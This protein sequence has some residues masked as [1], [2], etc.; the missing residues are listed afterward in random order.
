LRGYDK[1]RFSFNTAG[2]RCEECQG[3]GYQ[4]VGMHF[5]GNVEILCEKCEGKRFD[6]ETLEVTYKGK[7]IFDVLDMYVSEALE[8]FMDQPGILRFLHTMNDLGLGYLKL[9]QRSTTLSGGEAQRVKLA[10]E[11]AFTHSAHTLYILDEPTTGLHQADVRVLLSALDTLIQQENTVILIEHHL[12]VIAASYHVIDLGPGSEKEGGSVV[13]TGT[14]EGIADCTDSYTGQALREYMA[15]INYKPEAHGSRFTVH[16][17]QTS[18]S[19]IPH[20]ITHTSSIK[21]PASSISFDGV[22]TNN[23][24][25][26]SVQIPHNKITVMT[27][28][29]G[30]GKSSL[31]FDTVFAE[32]RNCFLESFSTYARTRLG[33]KDKPDF[34]EVSGLT[35]TLAVDQRMIGANP[36]STVG[37]MTGIYDFYRLLYAR[38][39]R[40]GSKAV[41]VLSSLFSFNHRHGACPECDGLG[42]V[43]VCDPVLLVTHPERSIL[44]GALDGTKTG[45]FY[46]DPY[47]QYVSTLKAVGK[48]RSVDFSLPWHELPD[49]A[50]NLA[51]AGAGD[52]IF[53][54]TWEYRRNKREG[55]HHFKGCWQGFVFL[56]NEEYIRKHADHRGNEMMDVMKKE[57][58]P[59]CHGARLCSEALSY[60]VQGIN[61]AQLS[62]ITVSASIRFFRDPLFLLEH[63]ALKIIASPLVQDILK[64]LEFIHGMGLSYLS[65][66][67]SSSTLSGG[68]AQRI[69][70]AGQIASELTGITYVLDEPTIGLHPADVNRLMEMIRNLQRQDNTVVIVEHDRD[71]ILSADHIIDLGPGAGSLGGKILAEGSPEEIIHNAASV[72]GPFLMKREFPLNQPERQLLP[73][74]FIRNANA[75]NLK[76]F[77]LTIPCGGMTV[78]TGV[79]GSGKSSL[80]FDVLFASWKNSKPNG[81]DLING[82]EQFELVIPVHP[83]S[84][85]TG[86]NGTAA[87]FTGIFDKIRELFAKS[88]DAIRLNLGK[89][90]F[91]FLN[92]EGGCPHCQGAGKIRVSMDFMS[93]VPVICEECRGMRYNS[94]VLSCRYKEKT[95]A[96]VLDMSFS[97]ASVF[98]NDQKIVPG[99]KILEN[100]GLGYLHLGQSLDTLSG[101]ESQR[102]MLA[103][104]L[105]KPMKGNNLY[106]FEEPSTGLHFLDI[107]HLN[108]LFQSLTD[109]GHTLLIIEHDPEIILHA[110][111]IIDL[112]PGGGD[113]GGSVV[114]SGRLADIL[115]NP[116]SAT[117]IFLYKY[118]QNSSF[119]N[120]AD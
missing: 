15:S 110:D 77:N 111:W 40:S 97:E 115:E 42:S 10:T 68:E 58:C 59:S 44:A 26:I 4:E 27:G 90:H 55:Q 102:L 114:A 109:K 28:I 75:N 60:K 73:G 96:E 101:G 103:K 53:D 72:T 3:A 36:R 30:S 69:R 19:L 86:S 120:W 24:Q 16:E 25:N 18:S 22:S 84:E 35:P 57:Q 47:G 76:G 70:L 13:V 80:L 112:G 100:V 117:G 31:A 113:M 52:E 63:P 89:N 64:R 66:D 37:T 9:G 45:K 5:M 91:S 21:H 23:L 78:I 108:E 43:T 118:I 116:D 17:S 49:H 81:C 99:L 33:M 29:S 65:V 39:G 119:R 106:L 74:L 94:T 85:F 32:G 14:P 50:K 46:G 95:I 51:M 8:F 56:V 6:N 83:R 88:E 12:G 54:V 67:R 7:N 93:D 104:E 11:L 1:S 98:Y 38:V 20:P 48:S 61:I 107:I 79:S 34:E 82:L 92:K 71:V 87:T 41:P 105:M 62:A 2:G